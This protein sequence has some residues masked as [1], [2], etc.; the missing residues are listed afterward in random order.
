MKVLFL[1]ATGI[2]GHQVV[3]E[4]QAQHEVVP[5]AL[6]GGE[7]GGSA[8]LDVDITNLES[9]EAVLAEAAASGTPYDA[10][11]NCAIAPHRQKRPAEHGQ[12]NYFEHCIDVNVRGA[13][14]V[15]EAAARAAVPRVVYISSMTA[16]LG[17]PRLEFIDAN[18]SDRPVNVYAASKVFG[19]HVGRY[20]AYRSEREGYRLRVLCLRL[21]QPYKS[22]GAWDEMWPE[23]PEMRRL[24]ADYRDI[25]Q[26]IDCALRADI[27]YGVYSIVSECDVTMVAPELYADLGYR[28]AWRFSA[29]GL[30]PVNKSELQV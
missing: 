6:G 2:V 4:L 14:H 11:V 18:T 25:A 16:V 1:G 20:Y 12:H 28:P 7:V 3:P 9:M 15:Y 21:G 8:V 5:A 17:A 13:Y 10:I 19:E 24:A 29:D 26:A 30:Q 27:E 23:S 22:F